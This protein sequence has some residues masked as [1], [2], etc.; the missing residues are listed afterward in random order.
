MS[1]IHVISEY[2]IVSEARVTSETFRGIL[3]VRIKYLFDHRI[4]E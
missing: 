3:K 1:Q 4:N 2:F